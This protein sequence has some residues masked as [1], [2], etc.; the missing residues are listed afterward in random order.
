MTPS[1]NTATYLYCLVQ[2]ERRPRWP[3]PRAAC[4]ALGPLRVLPAGDGLWLVAADA[5]LAQYGG[6]PDRARTCAISSGWRCAGPPT[7][8]WSST[9]R[10]GSRRCP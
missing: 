5:P 4:P 1:P 2:A 6:A 3:A 7:P 8:G 10:A 9:S